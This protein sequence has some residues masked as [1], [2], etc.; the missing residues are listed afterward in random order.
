MVSDSEVKYHLHDK[1]ARE[2]QNDFDVSISPPHPILA[3]YSSSD[4]ILMVDTGVKGSGFK[5]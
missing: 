1:T 3:L 5:S 2:P 4:R